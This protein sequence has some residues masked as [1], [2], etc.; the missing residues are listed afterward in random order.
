MARR[1]GVAAS[2]PGDDDI[3]RALLSGFP[4]RV[5]KRREPGSPRL[6][7]A[8][9]AGARLGRESGVHGGELL[10]A[11]DVAHGTRGATEAEALVR[12]ASVVSPDWVRPTSRQVLHRLDAKGARVVAVEQARRGAIVLSERQVEPEGAVA[13]ALLADAALSE[14]VPAALADLTR[15]AAFA[16]VALDLAALVRD[17]CAGRC[18]MPALDAPSI[19]PRATLVAIDRGAPVSLEVPSGRRL[20]LA[21][22]EGGDVVLEVK[23]QEMFGARETPRIGPQRVPVTLHLLSPGGRPVQVT[24]DLASFWAR[25]YPEVR[26]ELRARYPRHPWP[27]DPLAATPTARAKPRQR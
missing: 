2:H 24:R 25:G 3:R 13:G 18:T 6:L 14:G 27:D 20:P 1:G 12:M 9:G 11:L 7:L 16:G 17:A 4:D 19:V 21:Y 22:G 10:L 26:K 15:R 5:A 23:L 8:G